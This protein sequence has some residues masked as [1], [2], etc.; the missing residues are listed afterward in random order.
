MSDDSDRI[1]KAMN[2]PAARAVA[3]MAAVAGFLIFAGKQFSTPQGRSSYWDQV[4][5]A[6][7]LRAEQDRWHE[8]QNQRIHAKWDYMKGRGGDLYRERALVRV[9][10][11]PPFPDATFEWRKAGFRHSS[12]AVSSRAAGA[13]LTVGWDVADRDGGIRLSFDDGRIWSLGISAGPHDLGQY[14]AG[15]ELPDIGMARMACRL[16]A[17]PGSPFSTITLVRPDAAQIRKQIWEEHVA[18]HPELAEEK[19]PW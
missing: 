1:W 14:Q 6:A 8:R 11:E 5:R 13:T 3:S 7:A 15:D 9:G 18:A 2:H 10:P 12:F 19:W 17:T 4:R 16:L